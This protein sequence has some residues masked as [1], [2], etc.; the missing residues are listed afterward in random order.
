MIILKIRRLP[1]L[2]A[3]K[4]RLDVRYRRPR[5]IV[6]T[7]INEPPRTIPLD[8]YKV[9][10]FNTVGFGFEIISRDPVHVLT[11]QTILF[12]FLPPS[13]HIQVAR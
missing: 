10:E 6:K 4:L 11:I 9:V 1:E 2:T 7:D 8:D 12:H 5:R 3:R 13:I